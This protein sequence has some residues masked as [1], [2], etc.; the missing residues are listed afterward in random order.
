M[1]L[2]KLAETVLYQVEHFWLLQELD[3][4]CRA[5]DRVAVAFL[6][7][8]YSHR[9]V[10]WPDLVPYVR[11][12]TVL[13]SLLVPLSF[14]ARFKDEELKAFGFN[15]K[16]VYKLSFQQGSKSVAPTPHVVLRTLRNAVAHLPDFA[17]GT[18]SEMPNISF[19]KGILCCRSRNNELVFNTEVGF[20]HFLSDVLRAIKTAT[21]NFIGSSD[22]LSSDA[23]SKRRV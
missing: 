15:I 13:S 21:G 16:E 2:Q 6:D 10:R 8:A 3:E 12:N 7:K 17:A 14:A 1:N 18:G 23:Q 5:K 9:R 22:A 4:A 19:D 11:L 20:V